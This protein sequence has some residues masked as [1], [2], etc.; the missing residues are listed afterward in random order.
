MKK[1]EFD[2]LRLMDKV[3]YKG[4]HT[5]VVDIDRAKRSIQVG[6][7]WTSFINVKIK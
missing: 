2:N 1:S 7:Q 4:V 3:I 6:K 5:V